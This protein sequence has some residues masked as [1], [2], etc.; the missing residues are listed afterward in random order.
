METQYFEQVKKRRYSV[1]IADED[2]IGIIKY[3]LYS[4]TIIKPLYDSIR[5]YIKVRDI[6]WFLHPFVCISF[7]IVYSWAVLLREMRK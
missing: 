7:L 5:G 3:C 6:A 2:K 4:I 1:Y